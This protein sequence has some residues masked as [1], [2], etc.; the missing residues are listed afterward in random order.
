MLKHVIT[1]ALEHTL[2]DENHHSGINKCSNYTQGKNS[3]KYCKSFIQLCEV[4]IRLSDERNDEIIQ[5]EFQRQRDCNTCD[6]T[7]ENTDKY[8]DKLYFMCSCHI[9][10]KSFGS[11][12]G[13]LI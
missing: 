7:D 1:N 11:L 6:R 2:S 5:Q 4:R 3:A 9:F 10:Q 8:N 12:D 13:I